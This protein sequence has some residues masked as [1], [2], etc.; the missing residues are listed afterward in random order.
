M[1]IQ[2]ITYPRTGS[3]YIA[4]VIR[5]YAGMEG[6]SNLL[7]Y[8]ESFNRGFR[9]G[10]PDNLYEV[11]DISHQ[12]SLETDNVLMRHHVHHFAYLSE[13]QMQEYRAA[14]W[15]TIMLYRRNYFETAL[16]LVLAEKTQQWVL[17]NNYPDSIK[18]DQQQFLMGLH[19]VER[20]VDRLFANVVDMPYT[21]VLEYESITSNPRKDY[22]A[23]ELCKHSYADLPA[24]RCPLRKAPNKFDVISN[25]VD[26]R[27]VYNCF[28]V[29]YKRP[30]NFELDGDFIVNPQISRKGRK[31]DT[32]LAL[33][34]IAI[35]AVQAQASSQEKN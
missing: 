32:N 30:E 19:H 34:D 28:K 31:H 23:L 1:K 29:K 8:G 21:E 35:P 6:Q 26:L 11:V 17:Y 5:L 12:L 27:E 15:H 25:L 10:G 33:A 2:I 9:G 4:E 7:Y 14:N 24:R 16:S 22:A 18:I 20:V 3:N 13:Q